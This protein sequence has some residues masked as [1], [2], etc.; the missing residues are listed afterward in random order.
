MG[1]EESTIP[2]QQMPGQ[3]AT[4]PKIIPRGPMPSQ[5]VKPTMQTTHELLIV[6]RGQRSTGK[7]T[8][9][10]R[11][12]G[13]EFD[14]EYH[15]TS[16]L[17]S[18][19]IPFKS[20]I[21][22]NEPVNIKVWD[23][24]EKAL[25]PPETKNPTDYPDASTI[26]T[27]K[28]ADGM[29]ILVD[30]RHIDTIQLATK[31]IDN[32]PIDLPILVFS[33]FQDEEEVQ[34]VMPELLMTKIGR[35]TYLPGSLKTNQGL[36]ELSK[37]LKIPYTYSKK[38]QYENL[39]KMTTDDLNDFLRQSHETAV[40]FIELESAIAHMP[41]IPKRPIVP[42]P[43]QAEEITQKTEEKAP[44]QK[45]SNEYDEMP[46]PQKSPEKEEIKD[47]QVHRKKTK[48]HGHGRKST[49]KQQE[50]PKVAP[51]QQ[52]KPKAPSPPKDDND[53]FFND[54]SISDD[55]MVLPEDDSYDEDTTPNPLVQSIPQK[56]SPKQTPPKKVEPKPEPKPEPEEN[57]DDFF[58]DDDED[59]DALK[60]PSD[61][62]E[63][64]DIAPNPLV[65]N[66]AKKSSPK[67]QT[68][69]S[70]KP[71]DNEEEELNELPK[72]EVHV[73]PNKLPSPKAMPKIEDN[74]ENADDFFGDDD[75]DDDAMNIEVTN[76]E[77]DDDEPKVVIKKLPP[78]EAL[79]PPPQVVEEK[80][81]PA[82]EPTPAAVHE[83]AP[84][85][86]APKEEKQDNLPKRHRT[87]L[88]RH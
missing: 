30:P 56:K 21:F 20:E 23:T 31:I 29:V 70:P 47:N 79:K 61:H 50:K 87:K 83:T 77:E 10:N 26:D 68:K 46:E 41:P 48:L 74:D 60:L 32:A 14:E 59:D 82:P 73:I 11:M 88:R 45:P 22:N 81:A 40:V 8:L 65:Q 78:L 84:A 2:A 86:E 53:D 71:A 16:F 55:A 1:N 76:D 42:K 4:P 27:Y 33:N 72:K 51:V 18:T 57:A 15:P 12:K 67:V 69:P 25:L 44:E 7:T 34:P 38:K 62:D 37:W 9:I 75:E 3:R 28:R 24:V 54:D 17:D 66:V 52:P 80:P 13:E 85:H 35:F 64:E 43:Q 39:L 63:E 6:V 5:T 19:E 36:V 58:G 49:S